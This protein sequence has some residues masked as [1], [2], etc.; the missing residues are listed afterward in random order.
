MKMLNDSFEVVPMHTSLSDLKHGGFAK[1]WPD[2]KVSL[3]NSFNDGILPGFTCG[4]YL[5]DSYDKKRKQRGITM[6][7]SKPE[8]GLVPNWYAMFTF[9]VG[10]R[11]SYKIDEHAARM[12]QS[13]NWTNWDIYF[14]LE[15]ANE[16]EV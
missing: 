14:Y 13:D 9:D 6:Y 8:S 2:W 1:K 15:R 5:D 7:V 16:K 3:L 11:C 4:E 10:P 12:I